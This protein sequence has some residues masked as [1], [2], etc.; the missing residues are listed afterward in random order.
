MTRRENLNDL[1]AKHGDV[2]AIPSF[3][4]YVSESG[5]NLNWLQARIATN[6]DCPDDLRVMLETTT[7]KNLNKEM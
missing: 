1:L 6:P 3:R 4:R 2:L 5:N 7:T